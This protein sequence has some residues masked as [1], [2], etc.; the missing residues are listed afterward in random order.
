MSYELDRWGRVGIRVVPLLRVAAMPGGHVMQLTSYT[1]YN[2]C[3]RVC[4]MRWHSQVVVIIL[5]VVVVLSAVIVAR[6]AV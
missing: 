3:M 2:T 6:W 5:P 1:L 4:A